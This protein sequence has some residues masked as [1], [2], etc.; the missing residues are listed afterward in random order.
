[1]VKETQ[2]LTIT[3]SE[4]YAQEDDMLSATSE[5][6]INSTDVDDAAMWD[7]IWETL[8]PESMSRDFS[9]NTITIERTYDAVHSDQLKAFYDTAKTAWEQAGFTVDITYT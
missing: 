4:T 8:Q 6:L 3:S 9:D 2:T 5:A 7:F 1:M